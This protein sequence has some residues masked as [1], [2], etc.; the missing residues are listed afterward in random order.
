MRRFGGFLKTLNGKVS[1]GA[2]F[3][4]KH[5]LAPRLAVIY[6]FTRKFD[7]KEL[8]RNVTMTIKLCKRVA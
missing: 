6:V 8:L 3:W 2:I 7:Y 4:E 1:E 5:I